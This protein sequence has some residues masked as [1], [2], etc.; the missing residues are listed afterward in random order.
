MREHAV[1]WV[2]VTGAASGIG[3]GVARGLS[4]EGYGIVLVDYDA[5]G[6]R[7]VAADLEQ[8]VVL[9]TDLTDPDSHEQIRDVTRSVDTAWGLVNC[10]GISQIKHFLLT[11]DAEWTRILRVNLEGSIRAASA[12]AGVLAENG[13]GGAIVN[14][15]SISGV[16]PAA[17]QAPYA[18]SKAGVIGFT[19]GLAFDLGPFD[20][21]VNVVSPGIV[22]TPMWDAILDKESAETGV[23][24]DDLFAE[25]VRPIPVGR[26]QTGDDI[27]AT[28]AF[29]LGPG[30][31]NISGENI[32]VTG[33][34]TTVTFDFHAG[35]DEYRKAVAAV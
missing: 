29:L 6:L 14:V 2:V 3:E 17:L 33:G 27:A 11:E 23:P 34:M 24:A 16:V 31:R 7:R 19:T 8:E 1:K 32:K 35:A 28:C 20:I 26:P 22:R 25:Y 15:A 10:A 13:R 21:T 30:G 18:A 9:A 12:V 5:A 4:R